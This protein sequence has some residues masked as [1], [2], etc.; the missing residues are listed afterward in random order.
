MSY[1][2]WILGG[3]LAFIWLSRVVDTTR[4]VRTLVNI[5][6]P[7]WDHN[8]ASA[9]GNPSVT[10]I[11]P[12]RNEEVSIGQALSYLLALDYANYKVIA[13]NDRSTDRTGDVMETVAQASKGR[14]KV[15]HIGQLPPGWM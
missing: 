11:V 13:V 10:L 3:L 1:F 7:E 15:I 5:S 6:R 2:H 14:L 12:A 9:S 8:P 4:G